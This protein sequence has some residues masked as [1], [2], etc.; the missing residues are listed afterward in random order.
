MLVVPSGVEPELWVS[1]TRVQPLHHGTSGIADII[2]YFLHPPPC[3]YAIDALWIANADLPFY[4]PLWR[5]SFRSFCARRLIV[6][7][8]NYL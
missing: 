4:V 8:L 1:K 5:V 2:S 7:S 6:V 3:T